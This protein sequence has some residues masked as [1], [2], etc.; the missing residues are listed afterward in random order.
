VRATGATHT[1]QKL[2]AWQTVWYDTNAL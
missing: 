2:M 1:K